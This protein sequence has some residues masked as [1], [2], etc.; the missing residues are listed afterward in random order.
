M[1]LLAMLLAAATPT[2][3]ATPPSQ[4]AADAAVVAR[5]AAALGPHISGPSFDGKPGTDR[6]VAAQEQ[7]VQRWVADWL[8]L[9]PHADPA[10]LADAGKRLHDDWSISAVRLSHGDMLVAAAMVWPGSVF[11]LGTDPRGGYHLRWSLSQPQHRLDRAAD[12][13]L[14]LWQPAVQNSHFPSHWIMG[15]PDIGRLPDGADGAARFWIAASYQNDMGATITRQLSLWSW[16]G[17]RARPLLLSD[18]DLGLAQHE[19]MLRGTILHVPSKSDWHSFGAC[20]MCAGR[21][22][23]LRFAVGPDKVRALPTPT[24]TPELDLIDRVYSSLLWRYSA[25]S[26]ATPAA[27]RIIREKLHDRIAEKDP[28]LRGYAG[29][30]MGWNRWSDHGRRWACLSVDGSGALAFAF[31]AGFRRITEVRVLGARACEGKGTRA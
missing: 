21:V 29:M 13:A 15:A 27:L 31:D 5:A 7:A 2:P 24:Q 3:A 17:D 19:P 25:R 23:D 30:V 22:V 6:L 11:I 18:F 4:L 1:I 20:G 9:H 8:D 12:H 26:L 14:S 10:A 16:R 28:E